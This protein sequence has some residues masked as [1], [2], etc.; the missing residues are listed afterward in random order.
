MNCIRCGSPDEIE[1]H[2]IKERSQGGG[3]EAE[4]KE[5]LCSAC[6]DYEHAK[7]KILASLEKARK[8]RQLERI[9]VFEHRLEVLEDLNTP[10]LIRERRHYQTWWIDETTHYMPRYKKVG[11]KAREKYCEISAKRLSQSVMRLDIAKGNL[12]S[13]QNRASIEVGN[14]SER[15]KHDNL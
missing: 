14:D 8:Q 6:H 4:N 12:R 5:P 15:D 3:D 2:H 10:S 9:A 7:R 13:E 11:R 1:E